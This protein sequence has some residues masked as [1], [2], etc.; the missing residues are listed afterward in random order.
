M[1]ASYYGPPLER[2]PERKLDLPRLVLLGIDLAEGVVCRCGG[3]R[4]RLRKLH[5]IE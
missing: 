5:A 4:V 1:K 3:S 2:E